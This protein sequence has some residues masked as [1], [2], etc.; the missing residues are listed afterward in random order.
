MLH[1]TLLAFDAVG[2]TLAGAAVPSAARPPVSRPAC[3]G[4]GRATFT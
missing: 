3:H 1:D 4:D 2:A